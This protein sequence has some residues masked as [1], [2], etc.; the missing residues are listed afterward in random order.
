[1]AKQVKGELVAVV[2]FDYGFLETTVAEKARTA[3]AHPAAGAEDRGEHLPGKM[4][5]GIVALETFMRLHCEIKY[6]GRIRG[7]HVE[8]HQRP[9]GDGTGRPGLL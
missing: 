4:P 1:M 3:P 2:G 7:R 5:I 9:V 8:G 6:R